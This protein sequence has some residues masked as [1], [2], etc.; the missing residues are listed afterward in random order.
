MND[1][2]LMPMSLLSKTAAALDV[3][4]RVEHSTM[5]MTGTQA[6]R[7]SGYGENSCSDKN[8]TKSKI[9]HDLLIG[10]SRV[11]HIPRLVDGM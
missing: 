11:P 6:A 10:S 1:L 5:L 3:H 2:P 7:D 8:T 4:W 9:A